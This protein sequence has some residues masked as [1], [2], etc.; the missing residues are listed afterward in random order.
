MATK[1][2]AVK[3]VKNP[4]SKHSQKLQV[5]GDEVNPTLEVMFENVVGGS[6][7]GEFVVWLEGVHAM[8]KNLVSVRGMKA[9]LD[10]TF[11]KVGTLPTLTTSSVQYWGKAYAIFNLEGGKSLTLKELLRLAREASSHFNGKDKKKTFAKAIEGATAESLRKA[12]PSQGAQKRK[13][14]TASNGK[15]KGK[16]SKVV[17]DTKASAEDL[18]KVLIKA[19][20]KG[21][22]ISEKTLDALTE[23][24]NDYMFILEVDKVA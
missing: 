16:G 18:A 12:T 24:I 17:E 3:A 13:A 4:N 2:K 23:A 19:L 11:E 10:A 9:T 15:G 7:E 20:E 8:E 14:S 1:S 5:T 22:K 6:L 21:E